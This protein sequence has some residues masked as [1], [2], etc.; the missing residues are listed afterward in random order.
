MNKVFSPI[1][2]VAVLFAF[3]S[4]GKQAAPDPHA[5]DVN[6]SIDESFRPIF[7]EELTNFQLNNP[8][9]VLK[10]SYV[11]EVEAINRLLADSVRMI[12]VTRDLNEKE[13]NALLEKYQLVARSQRVATDAVA[14]IVHPQN[15]DTLIS[16]NDV[17]R[18]VTGQI[19][20]WSQL[21]ASHQKG[22]LEIVFDHPQSS[23]VRYLEDSLCGGKAM[24]G[25][26]SA[27][28][29]NEQ[30]IE[31]VSKSTKAI[32]V[33]GVD[34]LRNRADS[35]R[36][37][38]LKKVHVMS[39]SRSSVPENTN[40]YEPY[41]YYIATGEYPLTRAV[42]MICTDP[43]ERSMAKNFYFFVSDQKGQL[44]ITRSSQLL[45]YMPVQIKNVRVT[46]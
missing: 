8:E 43:R 33:V 40:S 6:V 44:I 10:P 16:L 38:F 11:S 2:L 37:Q 36:L 15:P 35:T 13:R 19:T 29:T 14:L 17:K 42:Y 32:G 5:D 25:N 31:Y 7:E 27:A 21:H 30:V 1:A 3:A 23:T 28:K 22:A 12:V 20:D 9:A 39:V 18:I 24:Q 26:L 34:W 46:D 45:P 41:Q 4:C